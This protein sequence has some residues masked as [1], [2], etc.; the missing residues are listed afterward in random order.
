MIVIA[1]RANGFG[2]PE[3]SAAAVR[4][5][6][7]AGFVPEIDVRRTADGPV[8]SHDVP[9]AD[10]ALLR[11]VVHLCRMPLRR[12]RPMPVLVHVKDARVREMVPAADWF[13]AV[14]FGRAGVGTMY[15]EADTESDIRGVCDGVVCTN[16]GRWLTQDI[17][18]RLQ[19]RGTAVLAAGRNIFDYNEDRWA[20]LYYMGVD[21]LLTDLPVQAAEFF[22]WLK[23]R[24][25]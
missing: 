8:L 7:D 11:D 24:N 22:R 5:C 14:T 19:A 3:N 6:I 16:D 18:R 25:A 13:R 23:G 10:A 2:F 4:A 9:R 20:E 17:V 15:L 1:H 21:G 12:A